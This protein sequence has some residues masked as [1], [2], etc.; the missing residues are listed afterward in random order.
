M[1][2]RETLNKNPGITT[3]VTAAIVV[4]AIGWIVWQ[5]FGGGPSSGG[6]GS[7]KQYFT[8]DDG[9]T[10]FADL[11][12]KVPP[13]DHNG[14]Q[15][16]RAQVFQCGDGKPFVGVLQRYTKDAKAKLEKAQ[17]GKGGGDLLE[18]V[19]IT[20]LEVKKPKTGDAGW[21]LQGTAKGGAVAKV[22]CPDGK[23]EQLHSVTPE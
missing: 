3:G 14:K 5:I 21:V 9:A 4:L 2:I 7:A 11:A 22:T 19:D 1:G 12:T 23:V 10:Y 6:M 13:F 15:A 18:D 8:D 20:G 17:S 16:V